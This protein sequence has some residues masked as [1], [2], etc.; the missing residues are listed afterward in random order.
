MRSKIVAALA[1]GGLLVGAAFVSSVVSTPGTALAQEDTAESS[2]PISRIVGFLGEVLDDLVAQG[3]IDQGQADAIIDA[4]ETKAEEIR[5]QREA[6][7]EILREGFEDG[8]LTAEEAA[9]LPDDHPLFGEKFDEAWE[10][11]ELTV[12]EARELGFHRHRRTFRNG[13]RLGA[14]LDDGG[15][16]QEEYDA[17]GEDNILKSIDVS[18]YLEDGLIT[19][20]EL[21]EI[22][23][24]LHD[25]ADTDSNA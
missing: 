14:V 3:T 7:R 25:N 11:G 9:A 21:R 1:A 10:D 18:E 24:S 17:L 8:V 15:I 23:R 4:A 2:G 6:I 5:E 16:S 12:E 20:E 13:L 22:H 19:L